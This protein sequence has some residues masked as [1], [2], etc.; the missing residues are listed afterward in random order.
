[1]VCVEGDDGGEGERSGQQEEVYVGCGHSSPTGRGVG[2]T[3]PALS[4]YPAPGSCPINTDH[5]AAGE[6]SRL[7]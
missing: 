2:S 3:P 5:S 4:T 6:G 7:A 1:M